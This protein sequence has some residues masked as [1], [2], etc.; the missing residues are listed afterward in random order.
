MQQTVAEFLVAT[1]HVKKSGKLK[2]GLR[3]LLAA[4]G[5]AVLNVFIAPFRVALHAACMSGQ[6]MAF[7]I[8][9]GKRILAVH[10]WWIS[11]P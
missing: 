6:N 1:L 8:S 4:S 9:K 10:T 7:W 2:N 3:Q 11:H 5:P